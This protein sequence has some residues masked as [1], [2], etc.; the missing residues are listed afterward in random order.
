MP[1]VALRVDL[2]KYAD[3]AAHSL[4]LVAFVSRQDRRAH[5]RWRRLRDGQR[6]AELLHAAMRISR[7]AG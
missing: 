6:V 1:P 2:Y 5:Q 7:T 3:D 4:A